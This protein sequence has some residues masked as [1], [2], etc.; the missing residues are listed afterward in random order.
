MEGVD[1]SNPLSYADRFR[2]RRP[3]TPLK[4]ILPPHVDGEWSP[5]PAFPVKNIDTYHQQALQL[6]DGRTLFSET[7]FPK[8]CLV[9][10]ASM[11][12][13]NSK[14]A[15]THETLSTNVPTK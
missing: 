15:S 3:G 9:T 12:L 14:L 5:H 4:S 8:F 6:N 1:L 11:T 2:I 7:T 10:G 13:T